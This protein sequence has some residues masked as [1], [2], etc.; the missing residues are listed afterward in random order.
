LHSLSQDGANDA[1][2]MGFGKA[3]QASLDLTKHS[4]KIKLQIHLWGDMPSQYTIS[5]LLI[6]NISIKAASSTKRKIDNQ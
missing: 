1:S 3:Y 6:D 5:I 4:D 2:A